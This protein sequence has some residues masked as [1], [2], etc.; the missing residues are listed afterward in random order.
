MENEVMTNTNAMEF[1][2][3]ALGSALLQMDKGKNEELSDKFYTLDFFSS[4]NNKATGE[5]MICFS[6]EE[7]EGKYF[8]AS[9]SLYELLADNVDIADEDPE[10]RALYFS[11]YEVKIKYNGKTPLKNDPSKSCNV[12][13][14][15]VNKKG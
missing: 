7:I 13:K 4:V 8:W 6:V 2:L 5:N 10:A 12:W 3:N 1:N 15:Q 11:N 14:F 9:T